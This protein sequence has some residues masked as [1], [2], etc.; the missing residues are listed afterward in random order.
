MSKLC[1]KYL[2][3][4]HSPCFNVVGYTVILFHVSLVFVYMKIM[5]YM[6]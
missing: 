6:K 4:Y 2:L 3:T 5:I 1:Q